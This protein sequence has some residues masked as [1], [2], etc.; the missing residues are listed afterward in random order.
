MFI[1]IFNLSWCISLLLLVSVDWLERLSV[2][3]LHILV[4]AWG[5]KSKEIHTVVSKIKEVV[6]YSIMSMGLGADLAFLA[7]DLVINPMIGCHYFPPGPQLLSQ[8]K[9]SLRLAG[10]KL[11]CLMTEAH[12][13]KLL[14]QGHHTM[15]PSQGSKLQPVNR[16]AIISLLSL[17]IVIISGPLW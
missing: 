9:R 2:L 11:Y 7:G 4:L 10:T 5:I 3:K 1:I 17:T 8:P 12:R 15:M 14:A 16:S 6:L 13:C